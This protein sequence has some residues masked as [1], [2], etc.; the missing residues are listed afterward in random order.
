[1]Q[2]HS[3]ANYNNTLAQHTI[4]ISILTTPN[5][6]VRK[7]A[8]TWLACKISPRLW[9]IISWLLFFFFHLVVGERTNQCMFYSNPLRMQPYLIFQETGPHLASKC[10]FFHHQFICLSIILTSL[11]MPFYLSIKNTFVV[12]LTLIRC[13][14]VSLKLITNLLL[15]RSDRH[16]IVVFNHKINGHIGYWGPSVTK[17]LHKCYR[18]SDQNTLILSIFLL[19]LIIYFLILRAAASLSI[20]HVFFGSCTDTS[21]SWYY[22]KPPALYPCFR[23]AV[24][25]TRVHIS[26]KKLCDLTC[27]LCGHVL[28]T[29]FVEPRRIGLTHISTGN[30]GCA[31]N[32]CRQKSSCLSPPLPPHK[33]QAV[34]A[35]HSFVV[36]FVFS[37]L[38]LLFL[39]VY[40]NNQL[41]LF[42]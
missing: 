6:C 13:Y 30:L 26:L 39:C 9:H 29:S 7:F 23:P 38:S 21:A 20:H 41:Y 31:C 2:T 11:K 32:S 19:L 18:E 16:G 8:T 1:M 22:Q 14:T 28:Q 24:L 37:P 4:E 27:D 3:F 40:I 25:I 36:F 10:L 42:T 12:V 33:L 17:R 5:T 35:F 15:S 34:F